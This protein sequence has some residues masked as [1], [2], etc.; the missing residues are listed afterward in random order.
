VERTLQSAAFDLA[1]DFDQKGRGWTPRPNAR[2]WVAQHVEQR[3]EEFDLDIPV[4]L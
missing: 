1:F 4:T 2:L 3:A